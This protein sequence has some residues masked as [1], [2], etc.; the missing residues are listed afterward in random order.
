MASAEQ[1]LNEAQYAFQSIS[2]GESPDNRRNASRA[3]SLCKKIIRKF[4]TTSE[5]AEAHAILRRLGEEVYSS[6]LS[7]EHRHTDPVTHHTAP[8]PKPLIRPSHDVESVPS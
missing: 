1:L 3:K 5:A 6:N 8:T 2:S 7:I 4:A